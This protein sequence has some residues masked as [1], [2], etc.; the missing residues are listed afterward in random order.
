[1]R[2]RIS[3]A[4]AGALLILIVSQPTTVRAQTNPLAGLDAYIEKSIKEWGIPGL[5]IAIVKGD[6]IVYAK[7][8][9]VRALGKPEPV[10]ERTLFAIGSNTK[11]FT[12]AL[13]GMMVDE[14]TMKFDDPITKYLP[15][16][17]LYDPYVTREF[18]LRDAMNHRSGLG[19][20]GDLLWLMGGYGRDEL[21][22]RVRYLKPNTSFRSQ[23]GYQNM[24]FLSA[25]QAIAAAAGKSWDE[26]VKERI[27]APLGMTASVTGTN[28]LPSNGDVATPH[29]QRGGQRAVIPRRNIDNVA[30]AGSIYSNVVDMTAWMRLFMGKGSYRGKQILKPET[31]AE[32]TSPQTIA[33]LPIDTLFPST[34][35]VMYGFGWVQQDY[36]GRKVL[37]HSGGIDGM[38]SWMYLVPEE[39][40]AVMILTNYDRH[41]LGSGLAFRV[42]DPYLGG[43]ARD[44][45]ALS[46]ATF[47]KGLVAAAAQQKTLDAGRLA[48]TS[49]SLALEKYAGTYADEMYG[50]LRVAVEA[51]KLVLSYGANNLKA[52]LSHWHQDVFRATWS[53]ENFGST[54]VTFRVGASGK[55][56]SVDADGL[57]TFKPVPAK[58]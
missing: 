50:D 35:F 36:L 48:G 34:H 13:A 10:T 18:T 57:A 26:L 23:F 24:M 38:L 41:A 31:L 43:P 49:P 15:W 7:G 52:P 29:S 32:L 21:L 28:D 55:V 40:L 16:F 17:Q 39:K 30:P 56:E 20:R 14:G 37:W 27:F 1:M 8:F 9:G 53:D 42:M 2:A 22:H 54:F 5:A 3:S 33:G 47:Q 4:A 11:S 58:P 44:Y 25:G 45:S 19:R 51:G 46:L 12:G 6:S